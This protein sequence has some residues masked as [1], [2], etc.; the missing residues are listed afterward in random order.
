MYTSNRVKTSVVSKQAVSLNVLGVVLWGIVTADLHAGDPLAEAAGEL[1]SEHGDPVSIFVLAEQELANGETNRALTKYSM[2]V[3]SAMEHRRADP[4]G[5]D[6]TSSIVGFA[7]WRL[8]MLRDPDDLPTRFVFRAADSLLAK[9]SPARTLFGESPR[10]VGTSL[11]Q[12]EAELWSY[13]AIVAWESGDI[14]RTIVYLHAAYA[15][16]STWEFGFDE[17]VASR[18]RSV[19]PNDRQRVLELLE[20]YGFDAEMIDGFGSRDRRALWKGRYLSDMT[21]FAEAIDPL[22]QALVSIDPA[23]KTDAAISLAN[24]L[25]RI[26]ADKDDVLAVLDGV[27]GQELSTSD[28]QKILI[29]RSKVKDRTPGRD[30]NGA[31]GDLEAAIHGTLRGGSHTDE[32]LFRL[33]L[34]H[35]EAGNNATAQEFFGRTRLYF[36]SSEFVPDENPT[37]RRAEV[38]RRHRAYYDAALLH[39][40]NGDS[41]KA[42]GLLEALV[43]LTE[44]YNS[45][46]PRFLHSACRFWLGR[47]LTESGDHARGRGVFDSI[48]NAVPHDYYGVRARMHLNLGGGAKEEVFPDV[49]TGAFYARLY[50]TGFGDDGLLG[51]GEKERDGRLGILERALGNGT[52]GWAFNGVDPIFSSNLTWFNGSDPLYLDSVRVLAQLATWRSL[53]RD[54]LSSSVLRRSVKE[55]VRIAELMREAGDWETGSLLLVYWGADPNPR[56]SGHFAA[57]YPRA[58]ERE[59][60][61]ARHRYGVA[62]ELLYA[63]MLAE[64][65]FSTRA[66]SQTGARGLFQFQP[67]TFRNYTRG[68]DVVEQT[69]KDYVGYLSDS[70]LS[71]DLGARWFRDLLRSNDGNLVLAAMEHNAGRRALER[72]FGSAVAAVEI[73]GSDVEVCVETARYAETRRFVRRVILSASILKAVGLF[74]S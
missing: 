34:R 69:G 12:F 9:G 52:Y 24:A 64:S 21:L 42:I 36:S 16:L 44:Q 67:T 1:D 19:D 47:L 17:E 23:V 73:C 48:S 51:A 72:W 7:L 38:E 46:D 70:S 35:K 56:S 57:L 37:K 60:E 25:R 50:E 15:R 26:G 54:A 10:Y 49:V 14:A 18:V 8:F 32:A 45:A 59:I 5:E 2:V 65:R 33:A 11:V 22:R 13:L 40:M 28:R 30:L 71:V 74:R 31:I 61:S 63:V 3:E 27:L 4:T 66:M 58:F 53:R 68:M 6:T 39:Y 62:P 43:D 41:T 55:R 20:L 29:E